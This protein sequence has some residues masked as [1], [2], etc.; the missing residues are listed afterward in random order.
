MG[1][2]AKKNGAIWALTFEQWM[3]QIHRYNNHC[4]YCG[5]D[6]GAAFSGVLEHVYPLSRG[7]AHSAINAVPSCHQCNTLKRNLTPAEWLNRCAQT[8]SPRSKM[9]AVKL[10]DI[11]DNHRFEMNHDGLTS[12]LGGHKTGGPRCY[13]VS[14]AS[15]CIFSGL[16]RYA[17]TT[18]FLWVAVHSY[19]W[20]VPVIVTGRN[21]EQIFSYTP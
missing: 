8:D 9:L 10:R 7:G 3:R 15:Q 16:T 14:T 1:E 17:A 4:F 19:G 21:G 6:F 12:A 2:Y 18:Q 20:T 11:I 13:S 5:F